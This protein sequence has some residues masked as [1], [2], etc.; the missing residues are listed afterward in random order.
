[1]IS[2]PNLGERPAM[3]NVQAQ[4]LATSTFNDDKMA[5]LPPRSLASLGAIWS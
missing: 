3:K 5:F 4:D 2:F 1:M